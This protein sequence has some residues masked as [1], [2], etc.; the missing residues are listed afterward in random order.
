MEIDS[1]EVIEID[2]CSNDN[3][4]KLRD[5][6]EKLD[7]HHQKS[8]EYHDLIKEIEST[9]KNE[10]EIIKYMVKSDRKIERYENI[11]ATILTI[12]STARL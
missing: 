2:A 1:K 9:I 12:I 10:R 8:D 7:N 3:L 6:V 11:C 5:L 4:T